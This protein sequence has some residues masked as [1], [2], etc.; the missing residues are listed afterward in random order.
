MIIYLPINKD[1]R[2]N[3]IFCVQNRTFLLKSLDESF[4]KCYSEYKELQDGEND[5]SY[6]R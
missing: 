3:D 5:V 2:H 6:R 1:N 4:L